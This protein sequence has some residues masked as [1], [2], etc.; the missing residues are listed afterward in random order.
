MGRIE[1]RSRHYSAK[2]GHL[3][4]SNH[5]K[6]LAKWSRQTGEVIFHPAEVHNQIYRRQM[7][8]ITADER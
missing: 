7:R 2:G 3:E 1:D 4:R 5:W 6:D 8:R